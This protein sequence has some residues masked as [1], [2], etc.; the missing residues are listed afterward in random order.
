MTR[1]S[2]SAS[3][4]STAWRER[5]F[6]LAGPGLALLAS[7]ASLALGAGT[8]CIGPLWLAAIAWTVA[9]SFAAALWRGLRHR[10]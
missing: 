10:D 1:I 6:V 9:A 5:A 7:A 3:G 2:L 4:R 8:Q